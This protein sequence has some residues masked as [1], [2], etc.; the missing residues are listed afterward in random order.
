MQYDVLNREG[1][2]VDS[3]EL[4]DS[5]FSI[6]PNRDAVFR[7]M[8]AQEANRRQ[9]T[10]KAKTRSEVRGGGRKPYRQKGTGR[11]RHGSIRSAQYVGGGIIFG[12]EPRSYR[13]RLPKKL[14]RL[15]MRSVLSDKA[16]EQK[17]VVLDAFNLS[18][19]K[20]KEMLGVLEGLGAA[21]SALI[22]TAEKC[23]DVVRSARNLVGVKTAPANAFSVLDILKHDYLIL[24]RDAVSK[25]EEVYAS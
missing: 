24:T 9:G 3:I 20:T 21:G 22:V 25:V 13:V 19:P 23:D 18:A 10:A 14:C 4:N 12:P 1:K 2:V 16:A 15:A 8:L 11:A 17:L 7:V 5:V 6:E